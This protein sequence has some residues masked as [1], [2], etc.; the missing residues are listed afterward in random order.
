MEYKWRVFSATSL[1]ILMA[2]IDGTVV[3]LAIYPIV[4]DLRSDFVTIVWVVLAYLLITT[5]FGLTLGRLGD[6][7][8]RK[9]MFNLGF[10][11]FTV[12][13][14]FCG[15]A[16]SGLELVLFRCVQGFGAALITAN[17]FAILSEAFPMRERGRAFGA[18]A[19]VWSVGSVLGIV[20]GGVII[21][22]FSWRVIFLI[23][24]PIGILG[25]Y[26]AYRTIHT[27]EPRPK[28]APTPY[29]DLPAAITFTAGILAL[30]LGVT[31]AI[32]YQD[33]TAWYVLA[34]FALTPAFFA[35]F[36]LWE[37]RYSR[38]PLFHPQFFRN[39]VF[40][41]SVAAAFLQSLALFSV[42]FLL[43]FYFEG[44]SG[45]SVLTASFLVVP[46]AAASAVAGPAAGILSDRIG[47]RVVASTGLV[48]QAGVIFLLSRLTT[49]TPL[50]GV[51]LLEAAYG[52][53][54]GFFWPANT[55]TIMSSS[56]PG[57]FGVGSGIM[58]TFRNTGMV[59]S[60]AVALTA[61]IA[62]IP[63][64]VAFS[65]FVGATNGALSS[66]LAS[67][68]LSGQS[69]AF[70]ISLGLLLAS[71]ALVLWKAPGRP[72][73]RGWGATAGVARPAGAP[74]GSEGWKAPEPSSPASAAAPTG[75]SG[76]PK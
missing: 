18:N 43:L 76:S 12:G 4:K 30:L 29:F 11:V 67:D 59:M 64:R 55:S 39:A 58:N 48:V 46:M 7:Y 21:T 49:G 14:L 63:S 42:N 60:F 9:L 3:L 31:G 2:G 13:S 26:W 56:P 51:A 15:L 32:I 28:D 54:G 25:T 8:G 1:A 34:A 17:A 19:V 37:V 74:V 41:T 47:P 62:V 33:W 71:L 45:V 57:K 20:L 72:A 68:Y 61:I 44:I 16:Q 10:A 24:I 6:L 69:F 27:P 50:L 66:S 70:T 5:T 23:N 52:V 22:Y 73:A 35:A 36:I 40:T 38:D 53:G 75:Y 65:L